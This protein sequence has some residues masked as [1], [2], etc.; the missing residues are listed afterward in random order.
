MSRQNIYAH[1]RALNIKSLGVAR[2]ARY[3]DDAAD[4]ILIRLGFKQPRNGNGH[5]KAK[6]RR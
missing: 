4:R 6:G 3:P 5:T 1:F 2:P